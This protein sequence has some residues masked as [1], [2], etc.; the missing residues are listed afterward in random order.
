MARR[1]GGV[2]SI[3]LHPIQSFE[4]RPTA[5][6]RVIEVYRLQEGLDRGGCA[7]QVD[8]A[9]SAFLVQ[10]AE[11]WMV[12]FEG[13]E[14]LQRIGNP[15]EEALRDGREEQRLALPG[16]AL[17]QGARGDQQLLEAVLPQQLAQPFDVVARRGG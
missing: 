11:A 14:G 15:S 5:R 17:E 9:A 3:A 12:P 8:E 1:R 10:T 2:G 13:R 7:A 16:R 6:E 4:H